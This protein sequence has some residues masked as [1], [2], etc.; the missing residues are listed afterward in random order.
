MSEMTSGRTTYRTSRR[1]HRA[2]GQRAASWWKQAQRYLVGGVNSPVRA[3]RAVGQEPLLAAQGKG[4]WLTDVD[5]ARYLDLIMGW[6]ALI[7]GHGHP[8]VMTEA[9]RQLRE[10]VHLGLT[11]EAEIRLAEAISTAIASIE[12]VRCTPSGTEACLTAI[13][14]ARGVTGR[15]KILMFEG[16]YHG[17]ASVPAS[18]EQDVIVVP[19]NSF[20]ALTEAMRRDG[21][22]IACAIIEPIA[23]N[24]GLVLPAEGWLRRLRELTSQWGALLIFDEVVT[25]FR[26]AYGGAQTLEHV[27]PDLTVL[28]KIIGGGFPIG[29]VGGSKRLMQRLAPE[30]DVYHAGTF[31]GHPLAMAAGLATLNVLKDGVIHR[32]LE[33]LGNRLAERLR[34]AAAHAGMAVQVNQRGSMLT[35]FFSD[36][37]VV[38]FATAQQSRRASFAPFAAALRHAGV[39]IPPSPF[40][41]WFVS[42]AH[43]ARQI[44]RLADAAADAFR[45]LGR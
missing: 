2:Q 4:P 18:V 6:G 3:F 27:T 12:Q 40:E 19:Y 21:E 45:Q 38:D 25:G 24:M 42:A 35:V 11:H 1:T 10:G 17:H 36:Q 5:G 15:S 9:R 43:D 16:C 41:T 29:A 34:E 32:R 28:G 8:A 26:L 37:A 33:T 30:G 13:R 20:E 39:L 44:D 23:A 22:Q 31:A 14:L 7:L